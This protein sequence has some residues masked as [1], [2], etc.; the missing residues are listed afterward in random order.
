MTGKSMKITNSIADK[1]QPWWRP[2]PTGNVFDFY[3]EYKN[4]KSS[5][6]LYEDKMIHSG[7]PC[8]LYSSPMGTL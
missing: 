3:Q 5:L 2:S 8:T 6:W 4:Y 7:D 1:A